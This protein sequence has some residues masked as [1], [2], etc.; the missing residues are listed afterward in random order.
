M[1]ESLF[2][3]TGLPFQ[4]SPDT[5]FLFDG[6]GHRDALLALRQGLAN[7]AGLMV[8]TGEIGAGKTTL[9]RTLLQQLDPNAFEVVQVA[10][11]QLTAETL[12]DRL[13]IALGMPEAAD[14]AKQ[15]EEPRGALISRL[16]AGLRP[17]LLVIDEAQH[18]ADSAFEWLLALMDASN[19]ASAGLRV[20]LCGQPELRLLLHAPA[21]GRLRQRVAIDGHLGLLDLA[22]TCAYIEHRLRKVAWNGTPEFATDAFGAIF[23][24]T[25]GVPRRVNLLC[26][27]LMLGASLGLKRRI[28]AAAVALTADAMQAEFGPAPAP[29]VRT[30][31]ADGMPRAPGPLLCVVGGQSDHVQMAVLLRALRLHPTL[32]RVRLVSAFRNNAFALQHALF[33]GLGSDTTTPICLDVAPVAYEQRAAELAQLLEPIVERLRPSAVIVCNGTDAA[34]A[35]ARVARQRAVPVFHLGA[36]QRSASRSTPEDMTRIEVDRCSD[37]LFTS[38][39]ESTPGLVA[40][41]VSPERILCVGNLAMDA[42]RAAVQTLGPGDG[43]P[44]RRLVPRTFWADP[45]GY[46]V[47]GLSEG[48]NIQY[49]HQLHGLLSLLATVSRDL[50]LVWPVNNLTHQFAEAFKLGKLIEGENIAC[51]PTQAHASLI[52]LMRN[53]TCVLTDSWSMQDEAVGLGVPCLM[54]GEHVGRS[55]S[56][57]STSTAR[58][59]TSPL[60]A[61]RALWEIVYNGGWI[62]N[63]PSGWDGK[64][65]GRIAASLS[66]ELRQKRAGFAAAPPL[67][68]AKL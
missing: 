41:G 65:A 8:L 15:C 67:L 6:K 23:A 25:G 10:G 14:S 52:D 4:L 63:L 55:G 22:E 60:A 35:A 2:G 19:S 68:S 13:A 44:A 43:G 46:G 18:L 34:L 9:L 32:P 27:R 12:S 45:H 56:A 11:A 33:D 1:Y 61:N 47:V 26:N 40:E 29:P 51:V 30:E 66:R 28:D 64:T 24:R 58:V 39:P 59:G 5:S 54:L 17:T 36:G 38:E 50:P 42:L 7:G 21:Q 37:L 3:L 62:P 31:P 53:A 57:L 20:C 48:G 49:R 16:T